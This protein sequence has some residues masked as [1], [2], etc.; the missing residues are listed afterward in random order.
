MV[1]SMTLEAEGLEGDV[2]TITRTLLAAGFVITN[3][4]RGP[5][6]TE[7]YAEKVSIFGATI[8]YLFAF[9]DQEQFTPQQRQDIGRAADNEHRAVAYIGRLLTDNQLGWNDFLD[10]LGGEVPSWHALTDQYQDH[11]S[12]ASRNKLPKGLKGEAWLIFEGLVADGLDFII[13]RRVQRLGA[14][15]RGKRVSDMLV[16]L[17]EGNLIVVDA[18]AAAHGYD[19]SWPNLRALVE[20]VCLQKQR[21]RGHNN[22]YSALIVSSQF[23]QSVAALQDLSVQFFSSTQVPLAFLASDVL[24]AAVNEMR[25]Q[26]DLRAAMR[27]K[28]I[29]AGGLVKLE[30][31]QKEIEAARMQ[32]ISLGG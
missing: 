28:V 13:G 5:H 26:I 31:I 15:Q 27:W 6:L 24:G 17:P 12:F 1:S 29:F 18:K 8:K 23:D 32:R 7:I 10:A 20:Y 25:V 3:A 19:A 4:R 9:T 22:V 16:Q 11:L 2:P 14:H 30:S 21:Q